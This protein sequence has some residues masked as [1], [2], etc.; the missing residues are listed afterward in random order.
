MTKIPNVEEAVREFRDT[1]VG[2]QWVFP[3]ERAGVEDWLR[4][5]LTEQREA[6][7]REERAR[8]LMI[9]TKILSVIDFMTLTVSV[10]PLTPPTK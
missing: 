4:N 7:A 1:N 8:I 10:E 5:A 3:E 9:A 6:G 2:L